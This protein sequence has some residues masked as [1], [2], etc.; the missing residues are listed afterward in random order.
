MA[1]S[2]RSASS[3]FGFKPMKHSKRS[4]SSSKSMAPGYKNICD[5]FSRRIASYKTLCGQAMG[6]A[7]ATR[8]SP[9]TLNSFSRWIEKGAVIHKVSGVQLKRWAQAARQVK[10][11]TAAKTVLCKRFGKS[12]IK[13]VTVEKSGAFL[14]ACSPTVNGRTFNFPC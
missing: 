10:S 2:F 3:S 9:T 12:V 5:T 11:A 6:P 13:A 4:G 7:K 8:P 14:V 1:T